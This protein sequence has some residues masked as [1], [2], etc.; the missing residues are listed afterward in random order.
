MHQNN[1]SKQKSS[2]SWE[3]RAASDERSRM[4]RRRAIDSYL[5]GWI[6]REVLSPNGNRR[7]ER[8]Y[9]G[10]YYTPQETK[11]RN[12]L[13]KLVYFLLFA[14]SIAVFVLSVVQEVPANSVGYVGL[15]QGIALLSMVW[16]LNSLFTYATAPHRM[17]VGDYKGGSLA[18]KKSCLWMAIAALLPAAA[19]LVHLFGDPTA[20]G[21]ELLCVLGHLLT[22]AIILLV[23]AMETRL[24]Y[25]KQPSP[26]AKWSADAAEEE[27]SI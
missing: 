19:T 4:K 27:P 25:D 14:A 11:Q 10:D 7:N 23:R 5:E 1:Q 18:L 20:R 24:V 22:G 3:D 9:V 15:S 6:V 13:R 8:I 21:R 26:D 17:T 12:I 2:G 16:V